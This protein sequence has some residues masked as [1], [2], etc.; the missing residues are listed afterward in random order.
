MPDSG[1]VAYSHTVFS[2]PYGNLIRTLVN[3]TATALR[4]TLSPRVF[5]EL[6]LVNCAAS[7]RLSAAGVVPSA[8]RLALPQRRGAEKVG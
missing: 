2:Q 5:H 3:H 4:R 6:T 1:T 7:G 8:Q